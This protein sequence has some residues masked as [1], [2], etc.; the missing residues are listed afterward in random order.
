MVKKMSRK[1][2]GSIDIYRSVANEC[3]LCYILT[4]KNKYKCNS[5]K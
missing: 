3:I 2:M 1:S 4:L 5:I